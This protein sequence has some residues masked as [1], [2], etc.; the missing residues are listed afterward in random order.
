MAGY[1]CVLLIAC[2]L[3]GAGCAV[4]PDYHRPA[5]PAADS[6]TREPLPAAVGSGGDAQRLL[7]G[8]R[9]AREWWLA[10]GSP[11]LNALVQQAFAHNPSIESAQAALRQAQ[12]NVSA[13]R[14]AY[15]PS[16]QVGYSASRQKNAVGTIS[17]TLTSGQALYTL[18]TAQLN[19]AYA[20]DVL[21]LNRR[22]VESLAAQAE[23]QRYQLEA[24][25]QALAS[26]VVNAAIQESALRAQIEATTEIIASDTRALAI[27]HRQA[28]LG[29][30]S[31]LDVAAQETAL[32]QARQ[33]LPPLQKQLE[34]TRDLLATL[35]GVLP[36]QGG[37]EAIELDQLQLPAELPLSLPS[38]LVEQRPD[39]RAAEAQVH[40]ASAQVGIA[41]ANRLPQFAISAQYS[42][43]STQ[44]SRMFATGNTFWGLTGSVAQS[45]FDFG[46][47]KHRQRAA[48]AALQQAAAQYRGV[49]L[50]AFQNVADSLYA[51][52]ADAQALQ[53]ATQSEAAARLTLELT[54]KQL[55]AG[56]VNGLALI[57]A[58]AAYQQARIAT[59]QARAAR[60]GDTAAL[61]LALGGGWQPD[62]A[63]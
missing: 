10:F 49:V 41:L 34:Q 48:E 45:V 3:A 5:L 32:A 7:P 20:P 52:Q 51:L 25:Y 55:D 24:A 58:Q 37:N 21:G 33:A 16:A 47:L 6:Y 18:H 42:G 50:D 63:H 26:N 29:Y 57:N 43:S 28:E 15:L 60:Y 46:T 40:A 44:F 23:S 53:A 39:V 14:G 12:E 35:T 30:A 22:T 31:G 13:Q 59:V 56:Q 1:R 8:P 27:L 17:P 62:P 9:I 11:P 19:I 61:I 4:G 2:A 54:H 38:Q 36:A